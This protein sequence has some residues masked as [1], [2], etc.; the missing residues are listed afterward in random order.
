MKHVLVGGSIHNQD[1]PMSKSIVRSMTSLNS[2]PSPYEAF[3]ESTS[4]AE[5]DRDLSESG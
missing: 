2:G 4:E 1:M 3:T 5:Y